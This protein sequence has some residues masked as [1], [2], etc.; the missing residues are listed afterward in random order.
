MGPTEAIKILEK[1]AAYLAA[2]IA[3]SPRDLTF[4]KQEHAALRRA[5]ETLAEKVENGERKDID[6]GSTGVPILSR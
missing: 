2:R 4:D 6:E 1:R 3:K 5:I